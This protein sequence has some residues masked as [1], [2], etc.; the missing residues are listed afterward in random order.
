MTEPITPQPATANERKY[1]LA[2]AVQRHVT[3]FDGWR[4]ES[5]TDFQ[6][7]LVKGRTPT[8]L[9]HFILSCITFGFWIPVW[10]FVTFMQRRQAMVLTVDE[11][12]NVRTER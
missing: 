8:H 3:G 7:V 5:Q 10:V 12:G 11:F 9:L 6:T 1:Q 4:V 2:M